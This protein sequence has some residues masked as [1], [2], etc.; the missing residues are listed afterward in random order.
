[1]I[2]KEVYLFEDKISLDGEWISSV[3]G[4]K[5]KSDKV[6]ALLTV[7]TFKALKENSSREFDYNYFDNLRNNLEDD[8]ADNYLINNFKDVELD[9]NDYIVENDEDLKDTLEIIG[10][11]KIISEKDL[12]IIEKE[13][14]MF[15]QAK[16][17]N[18]DI[19]HIRTKESNGD[20]LVIVKR[21]NAVFKGLDYSVHTYYN[22]SFYNGK[23]DLTMMQAYDEVKR[24]ENN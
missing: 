24:R 4:N 20:K 10:N 19:H 8:K 12:F 21:E 23:Y 22:N 18:W 2:L 6:K 15:E 9:S 17:N 11:V 7:D 16:K 3:S 13:S 5:C 1:M 14:D